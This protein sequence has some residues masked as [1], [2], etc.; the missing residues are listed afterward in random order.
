MD[1]KVLQDTP[2]WDWPRDAAKRF[3]EILIDRRGDKT[4]RL[5]AAELAGDLV[6]MNDELADAL[7]AIISSPDESAK[8]RA[9]AAL[10]LGPVLE[11][12]ETDGFDDPDDVPI[13]PRTFRKIQDLFQ[14]LYF[15]N[16][17]PKE[18]RRRILEAPVRAPEDWHRTAI[19]AAFSSGDKEWILTAVFSMRWIHGFDDRILAALKSA[20]PEIHYQAVEAAGNW[21]LASAWPD[22]VT[23][24]HDAATPKSLLLAAIGAVASIRPAEAR[25]VLEDL[26]GSDDEE[27]AEA[28][29]EAI[30]M[31]ETISDEE[32]DE[33]ESEWTN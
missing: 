9:R 3:Q 31:A 17:V 23:V 14:K 8:L 22:I 28:V 10:A 19:A 6:V 30:M 13:S 4:D 16:S 27:I 21:A 32:D 26:E 25:T 33:D 20:D 5:I 2:P 29:D 11:L 24:V 12:A 15:D 7:R 1:L 18:V